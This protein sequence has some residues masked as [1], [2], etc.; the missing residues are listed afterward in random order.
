MMSEPQLSHP[1]GRIWLPLFFSRSTPMVTHGSV[2]DCI[3]CSG[4]TKSKKRCSRRT[5]V[6]PGL[7][8]QHTAMEEGLRVKKSSIPGAGMGLFAAK[9]IPPN[10]RIAQY[11]KKSPYMPAAVDSTRLDDSHRYPYLWCTNGNAKRCWNAQSTQSTIARYANGCDRPGNARVC[12]AKMVPSGWLKS[13]QKIGKGSEIFFPYG[14]E[15]WES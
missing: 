15:Y 5:C 9:D 4:H 6:T 1:Q 2:R 13:T 12:N 14:S 8:W 11:A 10:R 7:C 3:R